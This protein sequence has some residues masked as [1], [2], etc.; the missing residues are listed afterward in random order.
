MQVSYPRG[1]VAAGLA[2]ALVVTLTP[3]AAG[4]FV[5]ELRVTAEASV[6]TLTLSAR[7]S[8]PTSN[9]AAPTAP[10]DELV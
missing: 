4:A 8:M 10:S 3:A 7:F 6:F 1:P 9:E 5:G 2:V